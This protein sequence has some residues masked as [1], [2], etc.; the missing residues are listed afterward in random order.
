MKNGNK[1]DTMN[2]C[3]LLHESYYLFAFSTLAND[4]TATKTKKIQLKLIPE[5]VN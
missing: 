4:V 3:Q 2:T 5:V 1:F